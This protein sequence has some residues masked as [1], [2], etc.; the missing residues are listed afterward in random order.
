MTAPTKKQNKARGRPAFTTDQI[1]H[2]RMHISRCALRLFQEE[3]YPAVSMRR[4]AKEAGCTVATIYKYYD[5]KIDILRELWMQVF[6]EL[7]DKIE[8]NAAQETEAI[9]RLNK[10]S[11]TYV[12]F[13]LK[14]RDHYF[15]VFMSSG[16]T[17]GDVSI[18]VGDETVLARFDIFHKGLLDALDGDIDEPT[19][20]V[21]S[22]LLLCTLNGIAHNLITINAYPWTAPDKLVNEAI[23]GLLR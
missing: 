15:M 11:Q 21:K 13:W 3:G 16:L 19:L 22:D 10:I 8:T 12:N 1:E 2:M 20:A 14:N 6:G 23:N 4:L 7:F 9:A 17:Q 5:R 18:F